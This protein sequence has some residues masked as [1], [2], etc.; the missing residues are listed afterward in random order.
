MKQGTG[1]LIPKKINIYKANY[2]QLY[3]EI[4]IQLKKL[5]R[6]FFQKFN[7]SG[8]KTLTHTQTK[9][10]T[11]IYELKIIHNKQYISQ[12]NT[13]NIKYK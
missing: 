12:G 6:K 10:I 7:A 1:V 4:C 5:I 9:I 3:Q 8:Y 13:I 11:Q 2:F